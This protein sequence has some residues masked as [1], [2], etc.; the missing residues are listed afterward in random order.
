MQEALFA[1]LQDMYMG[2]FIAGS[3]RPEIQSAIDSLG[4]FDRW[5]DKK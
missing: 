3:A 2:E 1:F 4:I 5:Y